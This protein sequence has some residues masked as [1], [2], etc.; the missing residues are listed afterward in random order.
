MSLE[1]YRTDS[2]AGT[3]L[4]FK[5]FKDTCFIRQGYVLHFVYI[6]I[7]LRAKNYL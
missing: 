7:S 1:K 4:G 5:Q 2:C 3:F 6:I